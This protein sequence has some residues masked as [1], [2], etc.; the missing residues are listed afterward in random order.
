ME[1]AGRRGR[2]EHNPALDGLRALAALGICAYHAGFDWASGGFLSV[3]A[4]FTLS[5]FLIT[6]LLL[7][8]HAETGTLSIQAFWGRR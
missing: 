8:E 1:A 7:A 6:R 5:G 3:S 2:L 4:F